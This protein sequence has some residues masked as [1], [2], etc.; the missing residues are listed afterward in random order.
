MVAE[1]AQVVGL[2]SAF[3]SSRASKQHMELSEFTQWLLE[4]G[5]NELAEKIQQNQETQVSIKA[6]LG[7]GLDD[8]S[9]KLSVVSDQ[10]AALAI[11]VFGELASGFG[12]LVV[13]DQAAEILRRMEDQGA[14]SFQEAMEISLSKP[15]LYYSDGPEYTCAEPRFFQDDLETMVTLGLLRKGTGGRGDPVYHCTRVGAGFVANNPLS[16]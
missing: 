3:S 12:E 13:S 6:L 14:T 1:F 5:L 2:L 10:L 9:E 7:R 11:P 16:K 4:H 8:V 15:V